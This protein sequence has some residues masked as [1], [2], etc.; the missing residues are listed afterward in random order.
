MDRERAARV[1]GF[2]VAF[3]AM[4]AAWR[5]LGW[6]APAI[7]AALGFIAYRLIAAER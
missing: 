1:V 5:A 2:G 6:P 7:S 4:F 3:A